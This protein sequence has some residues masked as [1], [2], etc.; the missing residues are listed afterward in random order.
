MNVFII[1]GAC[2]HPRE[3]WFPWLK[4]ELEKLGHKVAVPA[5]PTPQNQSLD[6]WMAVI[7]PYLG[8]IGP[9]TVLIAHSMGPAFALSL[10]ERL[11]VKL[12]ACVF[13]A[14]FTGK[15]GIGEFDSI[16]KTFMEKEFDWEKI[17]RNCGAFYLYGSENDP[18]VP[19]QMEREL[20]RRLG[21]ELI[22]IRGAG[23]FNEKAGYTRFPELLKLVEN[24]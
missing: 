1:H 19:L 16:N 14:G 15:L 2:G 17:R 13:V 4:L 6:A 12:K 8:K 24:L 22:L 11:D 20:A 23:H 3:N 10:L 21:A 7:W 18:Y 9:D 5:F